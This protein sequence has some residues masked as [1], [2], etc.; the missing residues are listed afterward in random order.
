MM[1]LDSMIWTSVKNSTGCS[2]ATCIDAFH[3]VSISQPEHWFTSTSF[4]VTLQIWWQAAAR[5]TSLQLSALD[6]VKS[7]S[8]ENHAENPFS[9]FCQF[10]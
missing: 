7:K 10:S 2:A 1:F 4:S 8:S 9:R 6:T 3:L 5:E